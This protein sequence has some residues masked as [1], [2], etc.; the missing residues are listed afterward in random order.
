MVEM[1][2]TAGLHRA[3]IRVDGG[4]WVAPP[5]LASLDDEFAGKVGIFFVE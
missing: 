1:P 4:Q 3:N 5:G 2:A